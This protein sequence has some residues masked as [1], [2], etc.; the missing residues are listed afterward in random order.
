MSE[1]ADFLPQ[2]K[3]MLATLLRTIEQIQALPDAPTIVYGFAVMELSAQ[4]Y[5]AI[6]EKHD[7]ELVAKAREL[8]R[9]HRAIEISSAGQIN[10]TH[11]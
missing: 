10:G 7:P 9:T 1:D 8:A 5:L 6:A 4:Q 3:R 2:V 11:Q